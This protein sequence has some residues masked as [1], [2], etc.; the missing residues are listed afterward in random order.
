MRVSELIVANVDQEL[1]YHI[2]NDLLW[3]CLKSQNLT[4]TESFVG[5]SLYREVVP[6]RCNHI[7]RPLGQSH[8]QT[9]L[10]LQSKDRLIS[11]FV[12]FEGPGSG[13]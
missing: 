7:P 2:T 8:R 13:T 4:W 3:L 11:H 5:K 10:S 6:T 9:A 1:R 12:T